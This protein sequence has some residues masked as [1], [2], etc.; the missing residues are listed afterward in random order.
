V[1]VKVR[2]IVHK[3]TETYT[4][5]DARDAVEVC[6]HTQGTRGGYDGSWETTQQYVAG[7][8]EGT[9]NQLW[10]SLAATE[11]VPT[12]LNF[13]AAGRVDG[14]WLYYEFAMTPFDYFGGVVGQPSTLATLSENKV[15]GLDVC[16]VGNDGQT[17]TP[18]C[19]LGYTGMKSENTMAW[20][21]NDQSKI[22]LH[23]L[24]NAPSFLNLQWGPITPNGTDNSAYYLNNN[25]VNGNVL[26]GTIG[27][28]PWELD[29]FGKTIH[30]MSNVNTAKSTVK[31]GNWIYYT[32]QAGSTYVFRTPADTWA[33]TGTAVTISPNLSISSLAT[34]GRYIY[35]SAVSTSGGKNQIYKY[36]VD[37]VSGTLTLDPN[38]T[39][40]GIEV[41]GVRG[42]S[43]YDGATDYIY[44]VSGGRNSSL[45]PVPSTATLYA[46]R[47]SDGALSTVGALTDVGD[48]YQVVR[49][50]KQLWVVDVFNSGNDGRIRMYDLA[51]DTHLASSTPSSVKPDGLVQIYG[52]A[53]DGDDFARAFLGFNLDSGF[54]G[55]EVAFAHAESAEGVAGDFEVGFLRGFVVH[56]REAAF[57]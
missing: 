5:W 19:T 9:T 26:G 13:Q 37:D 46:I 57:F 50:G 3:F 20:K 8:K 18:D 4:G 28:G 6:L 49:V 44:V 7:I 52:L 42:L 43:Y 31:V 10:T 53:V 54:A 32:Y 55:D 45:S 40:A 17:S 41:T 35:A 38:W 21:F 36:A 51:D 16:V 12:E 47:T 56:E 30:S 1:A 11:S 29:K 39:V 48:T 22:G 25:I 34:D 24:V 23:K 14:Q 15:I 2:D 33:E 27:V